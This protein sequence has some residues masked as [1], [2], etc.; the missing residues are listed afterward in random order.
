[1]LYLLV[2]DSNESGAAMSSLLKQLGCS[3]QMIAPKTLLA[4][5]GGSLGLDLELATTPMAGPTVTLVRGEAPSARTLFPDTPVVPPEIWVPLQAKRVR[6]FPKH[7]VKPGVV[8]KPPPTSGLM[9][10]TSSSNRP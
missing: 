8:P 10:W 2:A 7:P 4:R 3:Q 6:Y 1:M 5:L 9:T